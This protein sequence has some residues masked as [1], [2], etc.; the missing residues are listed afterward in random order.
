ML[1]MNRLNIFLFVIVQSDFRLNI[2]CPLML[3]LSSSLRTGTYACP[4]TRLL[5]T[6]LIRTSEFMFPKYL[7]EFQNVEIVKS[8]F[9][10]EKSKKNKHKSNVVLKVNVKRLLLHGL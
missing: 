9:K 4:L 10:S 1:T 3:F 2:F 6:E 5:A 7:I 8:K